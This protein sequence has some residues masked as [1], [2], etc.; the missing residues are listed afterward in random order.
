MYRFRKTSGL[1]QKFNIGRDRKQDLK[2]VTMDMR[3]ACI[4]DGEKM[5]DTE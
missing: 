1:I 3:T 2:Q 5:F 4:I